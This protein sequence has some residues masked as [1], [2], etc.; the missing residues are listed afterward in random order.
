MSSGVFLSGC[1]QDGDDKSGRIGAGELKQSKLARL[2]VKLP[3]PPTFNKDHAPKLYPDQ[4]LSIYGLRKDM[5]VYLNKAVRVKAFLLEVYKCPTCPKG[6]TCK[7][8]TAP[9]FYLSDRKNGPKD[10]AIMVTDYPEKDPRT[11]R[12]IKLEE[13]ARYI[14][15]GLFAKRSGTG[16]SYSEGLL[17]YRE[18]IKE[19]IK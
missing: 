3:S 5:S 6:A 12:K 14:V 4:T 18:A 8:C 11:R 16:F 17:V 9:H 1:P 15:T 7:E 13:G 19:E 2:E 10:K